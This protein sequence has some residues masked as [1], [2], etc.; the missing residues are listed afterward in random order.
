MALIISLIYYLLV[1]SAMAYA[2]VMLSLTVGWFRL[3]RFEG[4]L[5]KPYEMVSV[6]VA[7]RNEE[8]DILKLLHCLIQ[9]DYPK[10]NFEVIIVNDHSEDKTQEIINSFISLNPGGNIKLIVS[11]SEGK[12]NALSE[13]LAI[14]RGGLILT[15]DGDCE[16]GPKWISRMVSYYQSAKPS[17][18]IGPVVHTH[19]NGFLQQ[20]YT[21]DFVSLVASGAGSAGI[22]KPIMGNGANLA[23][24]RKGVPVVSE[25]DQHVSGDD[26]FL[27]QHLVKTKGAKSI[28]FIRDPEAIVNTR[29]PTSFKRFFNQRIR[30]ASKAKS[31]NSRWAV[32]V[33]LAVFL[34]N[35]LLVVT[36]LSGLFTSWMVVIFGLFI[37]FK[38]LIDLPLLSEFTG[39]I[40]NRKIM[41]FL[42]LFE[43][44]YPFYI[45]LAAIAGLIFRF[46][47][48]GRKGLR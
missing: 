1:A 25:G 43:L 39:F 16:M 36:L 35:F 38:F 41:K 13:G 2:V 23:F 26:V 11:K 22:G 31:Y 4:Q 7:V 30:W 8:A 29:P 12:K 21:L 3:N 18:I 32:L 33:A 46:E 40:S 17:L 19:K 20:F 27:I 14:A 5:V 10:S 34:F 15:T 48:K 45:V 37:L 42:P 28:H 47:W 6:V 44:I 9:Q 24:E